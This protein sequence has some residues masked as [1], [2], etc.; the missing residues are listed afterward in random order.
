MVTHRSLVAAVLAV[1]MALGL[2][3]NETAASE[4]SL[5]QARGLLE[6]HD[7][8][9]AVEAL[10]SCLPEASAAERPVVLDLLRQAY[11]SAAR[12]AEAAGRTQVAEEYREN[13]EILNRNAQAKST[14]PPED[15][16]LR[17]ATRRN[18]LERPTAAPVKPASIAPLPN[19]QPG[20]VSSAPKSS[21]SSGPSGAPAREPGSLPGTRVAPQTPPQANNAD[22][23]QSR[24]EQALSAFKAARYQEAGP[25]YASLAQAG[26]LPQAHLDLWLYCRCVVVVNRVNAKPKTAQEWDELKAEIAKI[27]ALSPKFWTAEY[28]RS[29]VEEL[30][31]KTKPSR[32]KKIVF[33]GAAP[34]EPDPIP[35]SAGPGAGAGVTKSSESKQPAE[36]VAP[37][38]SGP[39]AANPPK[40]VGNWLVLET[41]NFRILHADPTLAEK[42]SRA[43]ERAREVQFKH[44]VGSA[45][46]ESWTPR[47][48]IYVYP[49]AKIFSQMTG[50]PEDSPGFSTMGMNSGRIIARRVNVRADHANIVA[51]IVPHEVTHV[52]LADL[53]PTQ[54]IPRWADEGMAVLSEPHSEQVVRA[55]DLQEPLTTGQLFRVQDLMVMDYPDGRYWA[56]Y[57][58]QSV[59]LT[60]FLVEQG[61]PAQFVEFVQGSQR[62]G[63]EP[64]LRRIYK[65]DGFQDLHQRW[66]TYAKSQSASAS[67]LAKEPTKG[68]ETTRR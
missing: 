7:A 8:A 47:C 14:P 59:S 64:E 31:P 22:T 58:A 21:T 1:F 39:E 54:Q 26:Q 25:I 28:L 35:P 4:T 57:Y 41:K 29:K 16:A 27:Q 32:L 19:V 15:S 37:P 33:R 23:A 53:F 68:A 55:A 63:H 34:E 66:V 3:K 9:G 18:E 5:A 45:P 38:V 67:S 52:V 43:A 42:V 13:L 6:R 62:R 17:S 40:K 2:P 12:D 44:W 20:P 51:A 60:R 61:T 49:S 24:L 36:N 48:D 30:A 56:L 50:Q 46:R 10:E 65:I 11:E